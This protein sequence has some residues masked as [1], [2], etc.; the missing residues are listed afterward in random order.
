MAASWH[1][2]PR[3]KFFQKGAIHF[4]NEMENEMTMNEDG[5][6][7]CAWLHALPERQAVPGLHVDPVRLVHTRRLR[8]NTRRLHLV[9]AHQ[10]VP[11]R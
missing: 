5:D 2:D 10:L 9:L 8:P 6:H 3:L 4:E 1:Q 7:L 11:V